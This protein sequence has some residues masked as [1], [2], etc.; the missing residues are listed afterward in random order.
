MLNYYVLIY[1]KKP[2]RFDQK[3]VWQAIPALGWLAP[4]DEAERPSYAAIQRLRA[5]K[6]RNVEPAPAEDVSKEHRSSIHADS[7]SQNNPGVHMPKDES[8]QKP[9]PNKKKK[10]RVATIETPTT[11]S[12]TPFANPGIPQ[13]PTSADI[14]IGKMSSEAFD[15]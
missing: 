4:T 3:F 2:Q 15:E 10:G 5:N 13:T 7:E 6:M 8:L 12:T 1:K 11:P 9:S 14:P